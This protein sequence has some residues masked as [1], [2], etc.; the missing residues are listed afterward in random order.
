LADV[1]KKINAGGGAVRR[2]G[3]RRLPAGS[4]EV[5]WEG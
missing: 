5:D 3:L 1:N 4:L 2:Q